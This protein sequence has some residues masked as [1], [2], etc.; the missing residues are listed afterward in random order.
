M[1]TFSAMQIAGGTC[2]LWPMQRRIFSRD[3]VPWT[4]PTSTLG[5]EE[6]PVA[7]AAEPAKLVPFVRPTPLSVAL[8]TF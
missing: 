4:A 5:T 1:A 2:P 8:M 6:N 3:C 7:M